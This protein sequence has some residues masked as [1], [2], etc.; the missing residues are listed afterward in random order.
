MSL[1]I[2]NLIFCIKYCGKKIV[3]LYQNYK[4][5]ADNEDKEEYFMDILTTL[6][7]IRNIMYNQ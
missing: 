6:D 5:N 7:I 1:N 3:D 2:Y 4:E